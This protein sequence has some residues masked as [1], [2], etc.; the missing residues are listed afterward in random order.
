MTI[1]LS[2]QSQPSKETKTEIKGTVVDEQ[3]VPVI[4]AAVK[5]KGTTQGTITDIDGNFRLDAS[6]NDV[7]II[8]YVGLETVER[9]IRSEERRVGKECRS[10]WSPHH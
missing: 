7:V 3:G 10:R 9:R 4:G 6:L 1:I 2:P 8:S 5:L